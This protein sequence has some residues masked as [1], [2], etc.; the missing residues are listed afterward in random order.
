MKKIMAL[1]LAMAMVLGMSVTTFAAQPSDPQQPKNTTQGAGKKEDKGTITVKGIATDTG[2]SVKAYQIIKANY[3]LEGGYFSGYSALYNDDVDEADKINI[4]DKDVR[5]TEANLTAILNYLRG[6][7]A[8]ATS[9]IVNAKADTEFSMTGSNGTYSAEVPVGT[10][11]IVVSDAE[12]KIYSPLVVSAYYLNDNAI[13]NGDFTIVNNTGWIKETSEPALEKTVSSVT[14]KDEGKD[15]DGTINV[16]DTITYE[17]VINPVPHYGGEYP[18]FKVT[19]TLSKGLTFNG[20]VTF[21]VGDTKDNATEI[22]EEL[23]SVKPADLSGKGKLELNFVTDDNT[24][25]LDKYAGKVFVIRYKVTVGTDAFMNSDANENE[26][27]LEF[28]RD[29]NVSGDGADDETTSKTYNYTFDLSG[30][31]SGSTEESILTK[32]GTAVGATT[33]SPL[34][35]AVFGLYTDEACNTL[36]ENSFYNGTV[37]IDGKEVA[38]TVASDVNGKLIIKGLAAGTYYLK[39]T[40]APTGYSLNAKVYKIV[41]TATLYEDGALKG[42]LKE[43]DITVDGKSVAGGTVALDSSGKRVVTADQ[44]GNVEIEN[45]QL[46]T[47]PSTGGIGTTIFTIG[48]CAIMILAAALYFATRRKTVK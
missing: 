18:K 12:S 14:H 29:S 13:Q 22:T 8:D 44:P 40:Q 28:T 34:A 42:Q 4:S 35:N 24:Y 46:T 26:A 23:N 21:L 11:L 33:H 43:W 37:T 1:F 31:A 38:G 6:T 10:Y 7:G 20:D 25:L 41:V 15:N 47:L 39:E 45:T 9:E 17:V 16:G 32:M 2:V 36:Y 5:M 48:G 3:D 27:K 30:M 19:D